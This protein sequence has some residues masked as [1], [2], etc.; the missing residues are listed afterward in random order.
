MADEARY[1]ERRKGNFLKSTLRN[2]EVNF[3]SAG[4]N[5]GH[6]PHLEEKPMGDNMSKL[7]PE[8]Q[9]PSRSMA[10]SLVKSEE[11]EVGDEVILFAGK[12][13]V[14]AVSTANAVTLQERTDLVGGEIPCGGTTGPKDEA[15]IGTLDLTLQS[16]QP[17]SRQN[18]VSAAEKLDVC[19]SYCDSNDS[20]FA[21]YIEN[22]A[23]RVSPSP[24][25]S[26]EC[27]HSMS[28]DTVSRVQ[29]QVCDLAVRYVPHPKKANTSTGD[30]VSDSERSDD[31]TGIGNVGNRSGASDNSEDLAARDFIAALA[32]DGD[33]QRNVVSEQ[34]RLADSDIAR[35]LAK[36][37]ELGLGSAEILLFDGN[38][39]VPEADGED[40]EDLDIVFLRE[41]ARRYADSGRQKRGSKKAHTTMPDVDVLIDDYGDFDMMGT[42]EP[43]LQPRKKKKH[44]I[45][46]FGVSDSEL[47]GKMILAWEQDRSRKKAHKQHR[48]SLRAQGLLGK[49]GNVDM[50]AKYP[51][52]MKMDQIREE[53][54]VFLVSDRETYI[55]LSLRY[56]LER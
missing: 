25:P 49:N 7:H 6:D 5:P 3:I 53:L 39:G 47:E 2:N 45:M 20:A 50:I 18:A 28:A 15:G 22:M 32:S 30:S 51:G 14:H 36:Q 27:Q 1:T 54:R 8:G 40:D 19:G 37:E 10:P 43:S 13:N 48:E 24:H 31:V 44:G 46:D 26:T 56:S 52:G 55:A 16:R 29:P 23:A 12:N 42:N 35:R 4:V 33:E 11:S 17:E 38:D 41:Q 34:G 9:S 21:D